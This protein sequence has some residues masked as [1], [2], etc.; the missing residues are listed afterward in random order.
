MSGTDI[1]QSWNKLKYII[2]SCLDDVAPKIIK[3]VRGKPSL[4]S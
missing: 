1:N 3:R 2:T 4:L